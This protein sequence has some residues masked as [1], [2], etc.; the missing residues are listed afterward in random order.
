[1]LA[2]LYRALVRAG[3]PLLEAHL[4]KRER[5]GREDS[6]R[7]N[8]RRGRPSRQREPGPLA[9][10]HG[11]S[12][13]ESLSLLSTISR[14]LEDYPGLRVMVTTGT[15]TS[16]QAMAERLPEG[17]F[18]QY[19]P[20]DHPDWAAAFLDHWKP[21]LVVWTESDFWPAILHEVKRRGIPA[22]L[23]N[24]S[25]SRRSFRRWR[26]ARGVI[27]DALSAFDLCLAQNADH[28]G[29]LKRL[30]ARGVKV[31][32]S[33]KY[34]AAPLPCDAAQL[35]ALKAAT[36]GRAVVVYASTHPGE[37]EMACGIHERLKARHPGLLTVIAPRHVARGAEV[38]ALA[39]A[40]GLKVSV[41]SGGGMPAAGDDVYLA[42][43][44]GEMGLFYRLARVAVVGGSFTFRSHNPIEPAQLG[45]VVFYGPVV[46]HILSVC[47]DFEGCGGAK[48]MKDMAELEENIAACLDDPAKFAPM[49]RAA[50]AWTRARAGIADEV[51]ADLAPFFRRVME[52]R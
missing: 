3:T 7:R 14:A 6:G 18:H 19:I 30:G 20:V 43:T 12:V 40:R 47:E 27:G 8:E 16:A 17:A 24:G 34:A 22:V 32:A 45:C 33:L 21:G 52:G 46:D 42:D 25:M 39:E 35:E 29:R 44:M 50:E 49:A 10:F 37:E 13:G 4:E 5:A 23:L 15:V 11:A 28:G 9:W 31:S 26:L 36:A 51:A 41:R 1:M 38:K 2:G 48:R